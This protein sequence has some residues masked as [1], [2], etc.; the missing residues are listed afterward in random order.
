MNIGF[1][2]DKV[3]V[4]YPPGIPSN[5][6]SFLY[7]GRMSFVNKDSKK[8]ELSYRYPG[9][10]EQ[11]IRKLSH[12]TFLRPPISGNIKTLKKISET[13]SYK[14]YLISSRYGFLK[15]ETEKWLEKQRIRKYFTGIYFNFQN[16][17]PHIFKKEIIDQLR[18]TIYVDDDIDLLIYLSKNENLKLFW[19]ADKGDLKHK[20]LP[21][22][23][24]KIK[25]I[26]E[27]Y[28]NFLIKK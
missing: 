21:S 16:K 3:F 20:A 22:N 11:R 15:G 18:I 25:N 28:T 6:I 13:D 26:E 23:I 27:L 5:L 1:D 4:N 12:K 24:Y 14:T 9:R 7:K 8:T 2:F 19:I 10:I 17:Q